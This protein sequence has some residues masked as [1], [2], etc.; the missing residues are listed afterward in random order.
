MP[1]ITICSDGLYA[2]GGSYLSSCE[3][4]EPHS[5]KWRELWHKMREG[6][7]YAAAAAMDGRIYVFGGLT[8][9]NYKSATKSCEVFD[10]VKSFWGKMNPMAVPR[11]RM[12]CVILNGEIYIT[13]I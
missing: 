7:A 9:D 8:L 10:P 13:G 4:F 5:G 1:V 11:A 3:V 12:G 2:L 6:R